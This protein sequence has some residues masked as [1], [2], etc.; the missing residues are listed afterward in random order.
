MNDLEIPAFEEMPVLAKVSLYSSSACLSV[1]GALT[2]FCAH[3]LVKLRIGILPLSPGKKWKSPDEQAKE[4]LIATGSYASVFMSGSGST[5]VCLGAHDIDTNSK[6][7]AEGRGPKDEDWLAVMTTPVN[8]KVGEW[9]Q[10]E[11]DLVV[12]DLGDDVSS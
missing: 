12:D 3:H 9:Y 7:Q 4:E 5:M 10:N 11:T 1:S 6:F 8:R 2:Q